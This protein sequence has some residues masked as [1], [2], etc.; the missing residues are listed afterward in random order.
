MLRFLSPIWL[1]GFAALLVPLILHLW[2]RRPT[3]VVRVGSLRGLSGPPGPRAFGR[4]LNDVPLLLL[5]LAILAAVVIALAGLALARLG[6]APEQRQLLLV[7]PALMAD[8]L[9]VYADPVVDSLRRAGIPIHLLATGFPELGDGGAA[10]TPRSTGLWGLLRQLDDTLPPGSTVTVVALPSAGGVGPVRPTLRSEFRLHRPNLASA[11]VPGSVAR[12]GEDPLSLADRPI[13]SVLIEIVIGQGFGTEVELAAAAW[14]AAVEAT[15]DK[16]AHVR[17]RGVEDESGATNPGVVIWLAD[18]SVSDQALEQVH[19]GTILVQF[20]APEP[21]QA[22]SPGIHLAASGDAPADQF[23]ETVFR[24]SGELAGHP[25]LAD[26][27]GRPLLT[28]TSQGRGR[29]YR[30]ATRLTSDWSTLGL[31][32]DLPELALLT[33]RQH[34]TGVAAALVHPSQALPH[35]R[36]PGKSS[37]TEWRALTRWLILFAALLLS[38]ERLVAHRRARR[39]A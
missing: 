35:H 20:S 14:S 39:A 27:A 30:L 13:D 17:R 33:L 18:Q 32:T 26:G 23:Q 11:S 6:A 9:A 5:R 8:S 19:S 28:V 31:G 38:G 16:A 29:H 2:S 24:R 37:A 22:A 7:D 1:A 21:G 36:E 4:R 25:V 15:E 12:P 3:Q 34:Q 10:S